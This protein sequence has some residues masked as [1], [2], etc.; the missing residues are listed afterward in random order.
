MSYLNIID[1]N[2]SPQPEPT[3]AVSTLIALTCNSSSEARPAIPI[4]ERQLRVARAVFFCKQHYLEPSMSRISKLSRMESKAV[5]SPG[6]Q[7]QEIIEHYFSGRIGVMHPP[8]ATPYR[9]LYAVGEHGCITNSYLS[10]CPSYFNFS[11]YEIY[12]GLNGFPLDS[13]NDTVQVDSKLK[14]SSVSGVMTLIAAQLLKEYGLVHI[15]TGWDRSVNI[16]ASTIKLLWATTL[17]D[18]R[19]YHET[20]ALKHLNKYD[21][22]NVIVH[23]SMNS[24]CDGLFYRDNHTGNVVT[25]SYKY[26]LSRRGETFMRDLIAR[27]LDLVLDNTKMDIKSEDFLVPKSAVKKLH[28]RDQVVLLSRCAG[29]SRGKFHIVNDITDRQDS[30]VYGL[31]TMLTTDARTILNWYQYDITAALQSI[32]FDTLN[33][34]APKR[35]PQHFRLVSDR[36]AFR[37]EIVDELDGKQ[38]TTWVKVALTKIDNGGSVD[39]RILSRSKTLMAYKKEARPFVDAFMR[40]VNPELVVIAKRHAKIYNVDNEF[41]KKLIGKKYDVDGRKIFGLFFFVWTQIERDIRELMKPF[42]KGYCH[43]VHD[44]IASKEVVDVDLINQ[45]LKDAG[46]KYVRVELG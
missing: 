10:S 35:F 24:K 46:F 45:E 16:A 7:V 42:F 32:V 26:F 27:Y 43:D 23:K 28:T 8:L 9:A 41:V 3:I 21:K 17:Q 34:K 4:K 44:A 39:K 19:V 36:K 14:S 25:G 31:M 15:L 2:S 30:R 20:P 6:V 37:Q 13:Y 5:R 18:G 11:M 29:M 22:N 40:S 1:R 12:N 38:D 33:H